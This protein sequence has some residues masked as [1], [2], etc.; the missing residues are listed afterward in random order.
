MCSTRGYQGE[1]INLLRHTNHLEVIVWP[2]T[3]GIPLTV[4]L[5]ILRVPPIINPPMDRVDAAMTMLGTKENARELDTL[6][7]GSKHLTC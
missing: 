5:Y 7:S 1:T 2:R 3:S 6:Y 4:L